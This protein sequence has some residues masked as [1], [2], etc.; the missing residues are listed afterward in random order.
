MPVE[1]SAS[2]NL[3]MQS[4]Q[5]S[6]GNETLVSSANMRRKGVSG[7]LKV[8]MALMRLSGSVCLTLSVVGALY[9]IAK[10]QKETTEFSM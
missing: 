5:G 4:K 7:G 10:T 8:D 2:V 1:N 3:V 9:A 6:G